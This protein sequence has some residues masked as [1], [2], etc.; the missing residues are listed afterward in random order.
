MLSL[1]KASQVIAAHAPENQA[2]ASDAV[3]LISSAHK[4][5]SFF[6]SHLEEKKKK[7]SEQIL[8]LHLGPDTLYS[9]ALT[10]TRL[11][12]RR[13]RILNGARDRPRPAS[14]F[15][16]LKFPNGSR[17]S[18]FLVTGLRRRSTH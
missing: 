12:T 9:P 3:K 17:F 5:P 16:G 8:V 4:P 14:S 10:K 11:I 18:L 2:E 6:T 1:L 7:K 13:V 15:T